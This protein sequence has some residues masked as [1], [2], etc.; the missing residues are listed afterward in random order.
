MCAT[1][2][3]GAA[4]Q[5]LPERVYCFLSPFGLSHFSFTLSHFVSVVSPGWLSQGGPGDVIDTPDRPPGGS[6]H[7][8]VRWTTCNNSLILYLPISFIIVICNINTRGPRA[9]L[10]S[11][12]YPLDHRCAPFYSLYF[13]SYPLDHSPVVI[14]VSFGTLFVPVALL[15]LHSKSGGIAFLRIS[16]TLSVVKT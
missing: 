7:R 15:S 2:W 11:V 9:I 12:S 8:F 1:L 5:P 3:L 4:L 14:E 16:A 6:F 10:S 13:L